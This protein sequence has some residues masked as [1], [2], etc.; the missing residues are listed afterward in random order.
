MGFNIKWQSFETINYYAA[1]ICDDK[2]MF[3]ILK[4]SL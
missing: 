2:Y 1:Y 3:H 4:K